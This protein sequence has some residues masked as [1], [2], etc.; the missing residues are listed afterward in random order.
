MM[1]AG[2]SGRPGFNDRATITWLLIGQ[3]SPAYVSRTRILVANHA[4]QGPLSA[5]LI[6]DDLPA[7]AGDLCAPAVASRLAVYFGADAGTCQVITTLGVQIRV[8]TV[9]HTT[10]ATRFLT[11]GLLVVLWNPQWSKVDD[12]APVDPNLPWREPDD[13]TQPPPTLNPFTATQLTELAADP[14]LLP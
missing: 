11:G 4:G 8:A 3:P 12:S 1:S 6:G 10:A 2:Y 7:P 14:Q 5:T 13:P 9:G